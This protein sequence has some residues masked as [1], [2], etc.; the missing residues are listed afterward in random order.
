MSHVTSITSSYRHQF[1]V[2]HTFFKI[3][4]NVFFEFLSIKIKL[5]TILAYQVQQEPTSFSKEMYINGFKFSLLKDESLTR[6]ID[7]SSM[8]GTSHC[9]I[10]CSPHEV[11][12]TIKDQTD[13]IAKTSRRYLLIF[14]KNNRFHITY[15]V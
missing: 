9:H 15:C 3:K 1:K 8:T 6:N 10:I 11:Q 7:E 5:R 4:T 13:E 14:N 12:L 2:K